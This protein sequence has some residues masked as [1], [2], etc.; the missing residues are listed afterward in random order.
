MEKIYLD[1]AATTYIAPEVKEEMKRSLDIFGNPS[2]RH[3]LGKESRIELENAREKIAKF[4]NADS[5]EI[6]FTSGA[7]ESNNFAIRGLALANTKK[8]HIVISEIEHPSVIEIC[9]DLKKHGYELDYVS[10]DSDGIIKIDELKEKIRND[11]LLVSVMH[12]NN[13][14]GTIQPIEEIAK[15]CKEKRVLFHSDCVQSFGKLNIDVKKI[16]V[17]MISVSG[18]KLNAMKGIGFLYVKGGIKISSLLNGGGQENNLRSGT[19]NLVGI[20][21]LAK[22]IE[23]K[24][25]DVEVE[26]SRDRIISEVLKI[27]GS[28]LNGSREK[29]IFNNAS[30]SFYGIEGESLQMLLDEEGIEVS[31]GSA[32]SSHKLK[33]SHVLRAIKLPELFFNGS[34]RITLDT[35]KVLTKEQEDFI[36]K[37]IKENVEKLQ[38]ISP[39]KF[40]TQG[41]SPDGQKARK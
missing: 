1:N 20:L 14:I 31:T 11:T 32:C 8:R 30:F 19:E 9:E 18:H 29:R 28:R 39:F 2:S 33:G 12:V 5:E 37:K 35:L 36:V 13:E 34:I 10:V 25:N 3:S 7:T 16:G 38:K 27:S 40:G 26:K 17:D 4:I 41:V 15:I 21:S 22:A 6:I 23:L 24:R